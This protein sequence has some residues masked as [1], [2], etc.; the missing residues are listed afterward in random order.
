MN[1]LNVPYG[2]FMKDNTIAWVGAM[3]NIANQAREIIYN[4]IICKY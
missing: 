3:N 4:D 1:K 2:L